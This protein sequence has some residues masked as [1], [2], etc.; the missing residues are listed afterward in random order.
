MHHIISETVIKLLQLLHSE[1][2]VIWV[3]TRIPIL[4]EHFAIFV[5]AVNVT[6]LNSDIFIIIILAG[7]DNGLCF[8][9]YSSHFSDKTFNK[10]VSVGGGGEKGGEN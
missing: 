6:A 10:Y 9:D 8:S 5:I 4:I 1:N 3:L 7:N 2:S